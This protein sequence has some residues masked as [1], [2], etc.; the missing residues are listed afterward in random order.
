VPAKRKGDKTTELVWRWLGHL[1]ELHSLNL[2]G[3]CVHVY[4]YSPG[5]F[6]RSYLSTV[7]RFGVVHC[8]HLGQCFCKSAD[9]RTCP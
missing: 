2:N 6:C 8:E 4:Q 9:E 1:V 7:S 3:T 5:Y